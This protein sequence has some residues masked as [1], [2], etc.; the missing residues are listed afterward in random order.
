M[1][2]QLLLIIMCL[3]SGIIL[4]DKY[5]VGEFGISQPLLSA[6]ILGFAAG[7]F[8]KGVLLGLLLQPLWIV[9]LPIGRKVP[10]DGQAS[11]IAG[12]V[13]FFTL[14]LIGKVPF[15]KAA[16]A[17]IVLASIMSILGGWLDLVQ[18]KINGYISLRI[19]RATSLWEVAFVHAAALDVA[20]LRGVII[21]VASF[22]VS[23]L[24]VPLIAYIPFIPFERLLVSTFSIGLA[25]ALT[26][27]GLKKAAIPALAGFAS[28]AVVWFCIKFL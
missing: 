8:S 12:A 26:L 3:I 4:L 24:S 23:L 2:P 28:W 15:E 10:L 25:G 5:S 18:R 1:T 9:E 19:E 7:D 17:A 16:F 14:I 6:S 21:A 13:V 20:F 11:G 22:V 27:I